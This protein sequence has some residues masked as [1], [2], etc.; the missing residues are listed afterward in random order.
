[1][2]RSALNWKLTISFK[3]KKDWTRGWIFIKRTCSVSNFYDVKVWW[4]LLADE[5]PLG[6][7]W[8]MKFNKFEKQWDFVVESFWNKE[9]K[10]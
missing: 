4:S 10:I 6:V 3:T 2:N 8:Q 5:I 7:N 1:M 9:I